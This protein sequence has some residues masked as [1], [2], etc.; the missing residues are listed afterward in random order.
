LEFG[1]RQIAL[2]RHVTKDKVGLTDWE[3]ISAG[4]AGHKKRR[5]SSPKS[6]V[7]ARKAEANRQNAL[8]STGPKTIAGKACSRRNALKHGLFAEDLFSDLLVRTENPQ[9]FQKF[10]EE[11]I[12][13]NVFAAGF[14]AVAAKLARPQ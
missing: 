7:S 6:P 5:E 14:T 1:L 4:F 11:Q 2:S 3:D 12:G 13:N 8:H 10:L 9:Q